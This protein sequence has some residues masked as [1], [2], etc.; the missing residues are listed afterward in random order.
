MKKFI[1]L[2]MTLVFTMSYFFSVSAF[3]AEMEEITP[4]ASDYFSSYDV[5]ITSLGDGE[6]RINI[7][8][9]GKKIMT[10]IGATKVVLKEYNG[11]SWTTVKTFTS[12]SYPDL[13]GYNKRTHAGSVSYYNA[14][15]GKKYQATATFYAKDA[16]GSDT[17]TSTSISVTA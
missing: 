17:K 7:T 6:L 12:S 2:L 4:Y 10:E 13:M 5:A 8:A 16:S 9:N 3:A 15:D 14:T 1:T 11:S